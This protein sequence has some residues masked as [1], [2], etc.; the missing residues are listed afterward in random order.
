MRLRYKNQS[1]R[2]YWPRT[3]L[4]H[5]RRYNTKLSR[6]FCTLILI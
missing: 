2:S 6:D 5:S 3:S 1:R 4:L